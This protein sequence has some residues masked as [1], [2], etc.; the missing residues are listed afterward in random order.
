MADSLEI[1]GIPVHA[2]TLI[3]SRDRVLSFLEEGGNPRAVFSINPEIIMAARQDREL[4][5]LLQQGNFNLPDGMGIVW[6][7]RWLGYRIPERVAGYDLIREI[8]PLCSRRGFRVFL[9]GGEPGVAAGAARNLSQEFPGLNIVGTQHGFFS[10]EEED[11][12]RDNLR[13][14]RPDL[15][16]VGMGF[17]RQEQFI[18]DNALLLGIPVS[19]AVGGTLDVLAGRKKRA[20]RVLQR[21]GLE[22][23][24][25]IVSLGRWDRFL[26]LLSFGWLIIR[27]K[28]KR[29][30]ADA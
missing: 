24:Y 30:A 27:E 2:R 16:V 29:G 11:N 26:S 4:M 28:F 22:W 8:I 7:G 20:P 21:I 10:R 17:P 23:F 1:M 3:D 12:I 19:I 14:A 13:E 6:G 9:L 15:L 5:K 25:R 18:R